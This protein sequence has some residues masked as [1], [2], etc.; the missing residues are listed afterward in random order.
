[1]E[2]QDATRVA[3]SRSGGM[4]C[5][6]SGTERKVSPAH[7]AGRRDCAA[8]PMRLPLD[9]FPDLAAMASGLIEAIE[10]RSPGVRFGASRSPDPRRDPGFAAERASRAT[11]LRSSF[12]S[13]FGGAEGRAAPGRAPRTKR[14]P[15]SRRRPPYVSHPAERGRPAVS[16]DPRLPRRFRA[17]A[18]TVGSRSV[19][20]PRGDGTLERLARS[21]GWPRAIG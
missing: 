3:P 12:A 8:D 5:G 1:M 13:R 21:P 7:A 20:L 16:S 18:S 4:R 15:R 10:L 14:S 6:S 9:R 17:P 2:A 11:S 19:R